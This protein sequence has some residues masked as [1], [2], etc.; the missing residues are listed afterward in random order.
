MWV[1]YYNYPKSWLAL[2]KVMPPPNDLSIK[3][4]PLRYISH[5]PCMSRSRLL[6]ILVIQSWDKIAL[7]RTSTGLMSTFWK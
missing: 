4:C 3:L 1:K 5:G 6:T 2:S 7:L